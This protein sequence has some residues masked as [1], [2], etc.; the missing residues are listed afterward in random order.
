M[1]M[2]C[3]WS[4]TFAISSAAVGHIEALRSVTLGDLPVRTDARGQVTVPY[5]GEAHSFPYYSAKDILNG[6][7]SVDAFT[8]VGVHHRTCGFTH[9]ACEHAIPWSGSAR[10]RAGR[11][12]NGKF[13]LSA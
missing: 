2:N 9:Y 3:Y 5:R 1:A 6:Q 10:E 4:I 13:P 8:G 7:F 12:I 11:I